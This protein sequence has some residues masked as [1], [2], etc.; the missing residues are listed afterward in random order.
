MQNHSSI[1]NLSCNYISQISNTASHNT[2]VYL[3]V[4][5]LNVVRIAKCPS[6]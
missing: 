6:N 2:P 3:P 4:H 5:H 1:F